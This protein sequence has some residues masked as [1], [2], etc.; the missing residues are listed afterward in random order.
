[1][2][3]DTSPSIDFSQ[4]SCEHEKFHYDPCSKET[5]N[6]APAKIN[7]KRITSKTADHAIRTLQ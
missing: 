4:Y 3:K 7:S 6:C 1:M 5:C 2:E